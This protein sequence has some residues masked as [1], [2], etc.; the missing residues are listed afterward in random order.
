MSGTPSPKLPVTVVL[1]VKNEELNIGEALASVTWADQVFVVDS[2]SSDRTAEIAAVAGAEVVQFHFP[3]HGPRKKEWSLRNL[4]FRNEWVF[5]LD[6]DERVTPELR[7]EISE[8]I[9]RDDHDGYC[10]NIEFFFMGR[11]MRCFQR[12]WVT[13]LFRHRLGHFED[14]GLNDLPT[15]GDNEVHEHVVVDGRVGFLRSTLRHED[16]RDLVPWID[17]HN[18]YSTW[19][20][21]LYRQFRREPIGVGPLGFLRATPPQRRRILRRVWVRLPF[22]SGIR[23]FIWYVLRRGFLDGREGFIFCVLMGWYEFTISAKMR[24]LAAAEARA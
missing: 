1:P 12:I 5:L 18:R 19:E 13:R 24:E 11:Q 16:R 6:G 3:G 15:T 2:G 14:L 7:D 20:A 22:R 8:A 4:P 21:H 17:R 23:F 10:V 9:D